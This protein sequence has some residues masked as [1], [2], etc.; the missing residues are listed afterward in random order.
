MTTSSRDELPFDDVADFE[1]ADRGLLAVFGPAVVR[2]EDGRV[3]GQR[4]VRVPRR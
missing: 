1:N 2:A 3:M 4:G